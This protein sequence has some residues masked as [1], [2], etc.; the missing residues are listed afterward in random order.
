MED[1]AE[2]NRAAG[3]PQAAHFELVAWRLASRPWR[4]TAQ[5]G[6]SNATR[7]LVPSAGSPCRIPEV[8]SRRICR[9]PELLVEG[10]TVDPPEVLQV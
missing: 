8:R 1:E 3:D 7:D 9:E 10:W 4:G 5:A 6:A 2:H